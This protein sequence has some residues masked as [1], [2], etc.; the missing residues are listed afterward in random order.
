MRRKST[1]TAKRGIGF[2]GVLTIVLVVLKLTGLIAWSWWWILAPVWLPVLL[3]LLS[4]GVALYRFNHK[5]W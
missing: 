1:S 3:F 5:R 4:A 2:F